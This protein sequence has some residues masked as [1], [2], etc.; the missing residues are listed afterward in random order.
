M[1]DLMD[2]KEA[3]EAAVEAKKNET[4]IPALRV[5]ADGLIVAHFREGEEVAALEYLLKHRENLGMDDIHIRK[6]K[7]RQSE[8][9]TDFA[10]RW[11]P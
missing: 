1:G 6:V 10:H 3:L 11:W 7:L 8:A 9:E 2:A 5:E 4:R